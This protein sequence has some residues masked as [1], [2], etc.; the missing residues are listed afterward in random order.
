M[1]V[2]QGLLDDFANKNAVF[3]RKNLPFLKWWYSPRL[4]QLTLWRFSLLLEIPKSSWG[5]VTD[6]TLW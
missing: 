2:I 3:F 6:C 5:F 1:C 4:D